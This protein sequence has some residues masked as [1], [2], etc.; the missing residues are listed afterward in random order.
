M[1]A[2]WNTRRR[3]PSLGRDITLILVLKLVALMLL[4]VLFFRTPS[5][6][7]PDARTTAAHLLNA[8]SGV[9]ALQG[10]AHD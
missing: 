1:Q 4:W 2:A 9:S 7:H 6:P 8:H 3:H 5:V 10:I